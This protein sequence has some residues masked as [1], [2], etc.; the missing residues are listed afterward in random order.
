[1]GLGLRLCLNLIWGF[2][3]QEKTAN[4]WS[5]RA[6]MVR[7]TERALT[8]YWGWVRGLSL[9][10]RQT[11]CN[12]AL[13]VASLFTVPIYSQIFYNLPQPALHLQKESDLHRWATWWR[14][15][16]MPCHRISSFPTV[17][18]EVWNWKHSFSMC[19]QWAA[20]LRGSPVVLRMRISL[21]NKVAWNLTRKP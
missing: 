7:C 12:E 9:F 15:I 13:V 17:M 19:S 20:G 4:P 18:P 5:L 1:M 21:Q 10:N 2:H 6:T 8:T 11:C 14:S 3:T 16:I